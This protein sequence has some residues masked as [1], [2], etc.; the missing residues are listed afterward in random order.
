MSDE[1]NESAETMSPR[2]DDERIKSPAL[3]SGVVRGEPV[4]GKR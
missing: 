2:L 1:Y 3:G 4:E